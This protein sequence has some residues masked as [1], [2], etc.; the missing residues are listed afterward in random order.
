MSLA[1]SLGLENTQE[2]MD[3]I[4]YGDDKSQHFPIPKE[5]NNSF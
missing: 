4:V 1:K 3:L 2:V 5:N